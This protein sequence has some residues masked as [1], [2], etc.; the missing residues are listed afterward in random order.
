MVLNRKL[1]NFFS[2]NEQAAIHPGHIVPSIDFTNDPLSQGHLFSYTDTQ[3]RR[4]G[5]SNFHEI[6]INR[7][8]SPYHNFQ[9]DGMHRMDIDINPANY[10]LNSINDNWPRETPLA[11]KRDGFESY[12]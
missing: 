4:L 8:S 5:G 11:P 9:R 6:P 7:H 2:A 3:I 10:E 12:Q 1:D